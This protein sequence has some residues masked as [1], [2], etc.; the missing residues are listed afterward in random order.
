MIL[1]GRAAMGVILFVLMGLLFTVSCAQSSNQVGGKQK[2]PALGRSV[3]EAAPKPAMV[4]LSTLSEKESLNE[5]KTE[6]LE[7]KLVTIKKQKSLKKSPVVV[8]EM[9]QHRKR[10]QATRSKKSSVVVKETTA[11]KRTTATSQRASL[12]Q[13]AA[14][15]FVANISAY[16]ASREEGTAGGRTASG[17]KARAG[18]TIA[19]SRHIPMGTK[20]RIEGLPGI[21][22]VEDRGGAIRGNKLDVFVGSKTQARKWGRQDRKVYIAEWGNGKV[23]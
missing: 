1:K 16:T 19:A 9:A 23:D 13:R 3:L 2:N 4:N 12:K 14:Y 15:S 5:E 22:V 8:K 6:M 10:H 21:Y 17:K 20:V 18:R 11:K 7:K